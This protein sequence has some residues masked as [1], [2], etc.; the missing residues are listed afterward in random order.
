MYVIDEPMFMMTLSFTPEEK[1]KRKTEAKKIIHMN[2]SEVNK[3]KQKEADCVHWKKGTNNAMK[4][5][6]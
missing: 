3:L 4:R 1:C 5:S 2:Q 6:K